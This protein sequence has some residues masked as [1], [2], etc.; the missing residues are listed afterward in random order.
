MGLLI[1]FHIERRKKTHTNE[2]N[3]KKCA[4]TICV[5]SH[6]F[7][8]PKELNKDEIDCVRARSRSLSR[9]AGMPLTM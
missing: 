3:P 8:I 2:N 6:P 5:C 1:D 7:R 9:C 4:F